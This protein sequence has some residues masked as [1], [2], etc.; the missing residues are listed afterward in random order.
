MFDLNIQ[1]KEASSSGISSLGLNMKSFVFQ[2][3]TFL[4]VLGIL[5][6]WVFPKLV[7]TLE[8][9]RKVL[10]QSL[11]HAKKTEETLQRAEAQSTDILHKART[12]ADQ[13]LADAKAQAK[14]I[15]AAAEKNG[16]QS[17][18]RIIT[19]ASEQLSRE[20][21]KLRTE[22]KEELADL[23]VDTTEKVIRKRLS[24]REDLELIRHSV[25][26]LQR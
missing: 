13:A 9:R 1:F 16:E 26:E 14:E 10:E 21:S 12:Q 4:I 22:L 3:I 2:L 5:R 11:E 20:R 8:E 7:A 24:T 17:A 19:E 6:K 15:I 25:R 18:Q 23:V